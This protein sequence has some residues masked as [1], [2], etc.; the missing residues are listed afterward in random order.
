LRRLSLAHLRA[1]EK[2]SEG[3]RGGRVAELPGGASVERRR[4]LL[5]FRGKKIEKGG[6]Q[7]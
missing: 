7:P 3:T 4:G 1:V 5:L 2:L 6:N